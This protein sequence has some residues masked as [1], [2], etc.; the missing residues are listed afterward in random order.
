[1]TDKG[2]DYSLTEAADGAVPHEALNIAESLNADRLWLEY[3]GEI[4]R[5]R[6]GAAGI[7][8]P[9]RNAVPAAN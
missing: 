1:M 6:H 8:Q 9:F 5:R 2:M 3:A 4:V 7:R